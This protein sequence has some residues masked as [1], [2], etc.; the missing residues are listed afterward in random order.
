MDCRLNKYLTLGN[1]IFTYACT[2]FNLNLATSLNFVA[3]EP[4]STSQSQ[5]RVYSPSPA[6]MEARALV[7]QLASLNEGALG[8][9]QREERIQAYRSLLYLMIVLFGLFYTRDLFTGRLQLAFY[10]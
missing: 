1:C 4:S 10:T 8:Q 3:G 2:C 7:E 5:H 6:F 9:K